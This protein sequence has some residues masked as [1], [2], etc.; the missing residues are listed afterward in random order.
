MSQ[1]SAGLA[2]ALHHNVEYKLDAWTE[3]DYHKSLTPRK[4]YLDYFNISAERASKKEINRFLINRDSKLLRYIKT[5]FESL[6]SLDKRKVFIDPETY[7]GNEFFNLSSDIYLAGYWKKEYY[8]HIRDRLLLEFTFKEEAK[9]K[10]MEF[11]EEIQ[12]ADSVSV[13]IR[14]GDYVSNPT[15]KK[16]YGVL[17]AEY[18]YSAMKIIEK[19]IKNPVYFVFSD[20]PDWAKSNIKSSFPVNFIMHNLGKNDVEDIRLMKN[21]KH[22]IIANSSFS[23]WGAWLSDNSNK[24]VLAPE[25]KSNY[26]NDWIQLQWKSM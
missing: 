1:Y 15:Y 12:N 8:E 3:K 14:H 25:R 16:R 4:Y 11:L 7:I 20:D 19:K 22:H 17:P 5:K 24:I 26:P 10:N 23:W 18:Y 21:C 9:G 2:L 6:K 13:H